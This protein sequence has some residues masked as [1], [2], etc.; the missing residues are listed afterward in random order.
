MPKP[1]NSPKKTTVYQKMR[2]NTPPPSVAD[3]KE[4]LMELMREPREAPDTD[5]LARGW[6]HMQTSRGWK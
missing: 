3:I 5:P 6:E 1:S 4:F 2:N